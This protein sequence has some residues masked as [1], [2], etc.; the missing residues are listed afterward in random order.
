MNEHIVDETT[1]HVEPI[2]NDNYRPGMQYREGYLVRYRWS[3][4]YGWL[5][6]HCFPTKEEADAF[7]ESLRGKE[8]QNGK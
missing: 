3:N 4:L 6:C 8:E 7:A 2:T 1:S 5:C